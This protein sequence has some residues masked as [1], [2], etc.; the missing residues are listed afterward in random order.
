MRDVLLRAAGWL[1]MA[2]VVYVAGVVL[3]DIFL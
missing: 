1:L 2:A 3:L